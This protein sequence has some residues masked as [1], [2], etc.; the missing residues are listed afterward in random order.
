MEKRFIWHHVDSQTLEN[1]LER[2]QEVISIIRNNSTN[3]ERL[4]DDAYMDLLKTQMRILVMLGHR[5][6]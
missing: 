4:M 2:I 3:E 5:Q 1:L 6:Q